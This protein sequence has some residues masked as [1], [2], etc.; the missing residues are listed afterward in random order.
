M[1]RIITVILSFLVFSCFF[2]QTAL[3]DP[4]PLFRGADPSIIRVGEEYISVESIEGMKLNVRKAGNLADLAKA[5]PQTIYDA[6]T[7]D[8]VWAPD[9]IKVDS[10][11][12][13]YF[14]QGIGKDHRMYVIHSQDPLRNYSAPIYLAT[15]EWAIDGIAF[16]YQ[17]KWWFV[18]S[19]WERNQNGEQNIYIASMIDPI[20]INSPRFLLSQPREPWE[21]FDQ[22]PTLVNEA[23]QPIIDPDGNLHIVYSANG[24]WGKNYCLADLRLR[25]G[26]NVTELWDWWKSNGCLFGATKDTIALGWDPTLFADGVGH[27][28]FVLLNGDIN[29]SPPA[30]PH[31]PMAYHGVPRSK[32]CTSD[33]WSCRNWY[34]GSFVWW[35]N[36]TYT[37]GQE[38]N[39][40]WGLKFFE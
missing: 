35:G 2:Q 4:T 13:V 3:A 26:G 10:T 9:I 7:H 12:Y 28:S 27:N 22:N 40:G 33:F 24:S 1:L 5:I 25:K 38:T 23:P 15:G 30:G 8:E 37:R 21:R 6:K 19:G 17:S 31:F 14:T 32:P 20:T 36:V 34:I 18:W 16:Q 29:T 11:Y 39:V